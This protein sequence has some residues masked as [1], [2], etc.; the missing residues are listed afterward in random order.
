METPCLCPSE[1]H[2]YGGHKVTETCHLVLL[3]K[4]KIIALELRQ[5]E[6]NISSSASTVQFPKQKI[7]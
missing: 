2:K 1:G 4:R 3:L 6:R 7:K 5:I